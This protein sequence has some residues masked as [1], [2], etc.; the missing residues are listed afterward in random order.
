MQLTSAV[1]VMWPQ[2]LLA[3]ISP[4][5]ASLAHV[6]MPVFTAVAADNVL[7]ARLAGLSLLDWLQLWSSQITL[8]SHVDDDADVS[9]LCNILRQCTKLQV[10]E[11]FDVSDAACILDAIT[12]PAHRVSS[13][14]VDG[15]GNVAELMANVARWLTTGHATHLDLTY[16]VSSDGEVNHPALATMLTMTTE[17][18]HLALSLDAPGLLAPLVPPITSLIETMAVRRIMFHD[19]VDLDR[20]VLCSPT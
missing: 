17:L 9:R 7:A 18:E 3:A 10:V 12:T 14:Q 16:Y 8:Y 2:L 15:K 13:L 20:L 4:N 19:D 6:A 1:D 5:L 11:M